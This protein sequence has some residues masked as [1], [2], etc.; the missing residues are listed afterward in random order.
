MNRF[1]LSI[2]LVVISVTTIYSQ[3]QTISYGAGYANDVFYSVKNGLVQSSPRN[4]WDIGFATSK[5]S[6]SLLVNSGAGAMLFSYPNGDTSA[7]NTL[8]TNGISNWNPMYDSEESWEEGA[9]GLYATGHP[10]YGWGVYNMITHN[11]TGDSLFVIKTVSG[12]YLKLW[13]QGKESAAG[14]YH[15]L[16]ANLDGSNQNSVTLNTNSYMDKNFLYYDLTSKQVVDQEPVSADWD[17]MFT[18]YMAEQPTGGYYPVTGVLSNYGVEIARVEGV[19]TSLTNWSDFSFSD[20]K[21][22]IGWDWKAFSMTTMTYQCQDSLVFF[23]KNQDGDVYK[24]IFTDFAGTSSGNV[25]FTK[26]KLSSVG[27][28]EITENMIRIFPNP[29][30]DY[31]V[32]ET[33]LE[34][35]YQIEIFDLA[36]KRQLSEFASRAIT[37]IDV[38]NLNSGIYLLRIL[39][40]QNIIKTQ[41]FIVK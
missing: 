41:K 12:S 21:A 2:C 40:N 20:Q 7:W 16:F 38:Q 39:S 28:S 26:T 29:V 31:L 32:I 22:V 8:D 33:G 35:E 9:F 3:T 1:I 11:L 15:F 36:G 34:S 17:I 10:D 19:D 13:I 27:F 37:K 14:I 24:L 23:V 5:M 18:K 6:S 30:N 4:T 25:S